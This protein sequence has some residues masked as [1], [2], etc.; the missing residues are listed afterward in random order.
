MTNGESAQQKFCHTQEQW[1]KMLL[2]R[3]R[4]MK[5]EKEKADDKQCEHG[6]HRYKYSDK[7]GRK[8]TTKCMPYDTYKEMMNNK[9]VRYTRRSDS[10]SAQSQTGSRPKDVLR[11]YSDGQRRSPLGNEISPTESH[12]LLMRQLTSQG[13]SP[14]RLEEAISGV[15]KTVNIEDFLESS[16]KSM[17]P[18]ERQIMNEALD[19]AYTK[20]FTDL[21]LSSNKY[22]LY[23][24]S[25]QFQPDTSI[26]VLNLELQKIKSTMKNQSN[27]HIP[28]L[29]QYIKGNL[30]LKETKL[31]EENKKNENAIKIQKK[32]RQTKKRINQRKEDQQKQE[33]QKEIDD[34]KN[35]KDASIE[36]RNKKIGE[37]QNDNAAIQDQVAQLR[38][39]NAAIQDQIEQ[40]RNE[41]RLA[42]EK[43]EE[44]AA[45]V[46]LNPKTAYKAVL[47]E[48]CERVSG[49]VQGLIDTNSALNQNYEDLIR[50]LANSSVASQ[51]L[52]AENK[53]E[54]DTWFGEKQKSLT[55]LEQLTNEVKD[56]V[57]DDAPAA[58]IID[59]CTIAGQL[60]VQYNNLTDDLRYKSIFTNFKEDLGGAVRV[61]I[62]IRPNETENTL[63][64]E[65]KMVKIKYETSPDATLQECTKYNGKVGPFF[66]VYER[67]TNEDMFGRSNDLI[68]SSDDVDPKLIGTVS[69]VLDGYSIILFGY[70]LSGS[71]KTYTLLGQNEKPGSASVQGLIHFAFKY[72]QQQYATIQVEY[73]FEQYVRAVNVT[74]NGAMT[75]DIIELYRRKGFT[76][77][78]DGVSVHSGNFQ[79]NGIDMDKF[80]EVQINKLTSQTEELR[81]NDRIRRVKKTPNNDESSRS[82]LFMVF[83]VTTADKRKSGYITFIDTAG[84]ESPV[85]IFNTFIK[86]NIT[87][88]TAVGSNPTN[89]SPHIKEKYTKD[90]AYTPRNIIEIL[91]EGF[92]INET[93]NHLVAFF[94]K[95]N[96]QALQIQGI[97]K[98]GKKDLMDSNRFFVNPSNKDK[99][100]AI[101]MIQILQ[102]LDKLAGP[103]TITKFCVIV[104]VRQEPKYCSETKSSL[105]FADSISSTITIKEGG[106]MAA[107][108]G[109]GGGGGG[110]S[111]GTLQYREEA[112]GGGGGEGGEG[113]EGV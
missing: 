13:I 36:K 92:Y 88:E 26:D 113:E 24:Q 79:Y 91:K 98:D 104:A 18:Q 48:D 49:K 22:P 105:D 20:L 60:Y 67:T 76:G 37:L 111:I 90:P 46:A 52:F 82:H 7:F 71:G 99:S 33:R 80:N 15:G 57:S 51:Q 97:M 94:K 93:I 102:F 16:R 63:T 101:G 58:D 44:A 62:K 85:S 108:G 17:S 1:K 81:K 59:K 73:I 75:G 72:F 12:E 106:G 23:A 19:V 10:A 50:K 78:K 69:Q 83:K 66:N 38:D 42:Q 61:F 65:G 29:E 103:G 4:K 41:L 2:R 11:Q 40:L 64:K 96:G 14:E 30:E 21:L 43:A 34:I 54:L 68:S 39:D 53:Q 87:I 55:Q 27:E 32:F 56:L 28:L 95:K 86:P 70:G 35:G 9:Y 5:L 107:G 110:R 8:K 25:I 89:L 3:S 47:P 74:G 100:N 109:G 45:A 31:K 112:G 84:R 6:L 77:V